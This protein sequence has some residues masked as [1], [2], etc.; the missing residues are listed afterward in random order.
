M[1]LGARPDTVENLNI[2]V[3]TVEV[4][5]AIASEVALATG[6]SKR[7]SHALPWILG[8]TNVGL[9]I[10]QA[11]MFGPELD[12]GFDRHSRL[13]GHVNHLLIQALG[14]HLNLDDASRSGDSLEQ[15]LPKLV[16]A[17]GNAALAVNAQSK[18][19]DLRACLQHGC[20]RISAVGSMYLRRETNDVVIRVRTVRPLVRVRPDAKLELKARRTVSAA[21]NCSVSRLR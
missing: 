13:V 17:L 10:P 16:T 12:A 4:A 14:M 6:D 9:M 19:A 2:R 5:I 8:L 21:M 11:L 7:P 20:E 18:S 1:P 15:R 3:L